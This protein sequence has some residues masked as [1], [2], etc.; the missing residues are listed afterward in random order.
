M[1]TDYYNY[2]NHYYYY[3]HHYL[4]YVC[5]CHCRTASERGRKGVE[6]TSSEM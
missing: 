3:Y 2:S 1:T 4:W 6:G 5:Q